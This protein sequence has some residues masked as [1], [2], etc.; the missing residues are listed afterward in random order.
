MRCA[1]TLALLTPP[2]LILLLFVLTSLVE[3]P[4]LSMSLLLPAVVVGRFSTGLLTILVLVITIILTIP[5]SN[6]HS[7]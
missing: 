6:A 4:M 7:G 1:W 2:I 3:I 5:A